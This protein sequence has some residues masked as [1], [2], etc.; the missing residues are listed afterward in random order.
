V[1]LEGES[2]RQ[3]LQ[4]RTRELDIEARVVFLDQFVDQRTLIHF[5]S[6]S[7][8]YVLA[9]GRGIL[10]PFEDPAALGIEITALLTDHARR[11][12]LQK[13]AYAYSRSMI[14]QRVAS[15]RH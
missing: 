14:W 10:V 8:V 4:Q 9:D 1:R 2:Y 3:R 7:D 11:Q 13:A 12:G 6:M 15:L 5:I